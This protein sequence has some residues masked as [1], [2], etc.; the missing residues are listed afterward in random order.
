M[1]VHS[2]MF[3]LF[4]KLELSFLMALLLIASVFY[5]VPRVEALTVSPV[6]AELKA[7]PGQQLRTTFI[8]TNEER[9]TKTFYLSAQNFSAKDESGTPQFSPKKEGLAA[10]AQLPQ[11][12]TLG[13]KEQKEVTYTVSI[14]A[15][16]EPGGYFASIF[17]STLPPE[18]Q[19]NG[20]ISLGSKVGMLVLLRVG[21]AITES[22]DIV[23][24]ETKNKQALFLS[25]PVDFYF[26]FQ[27]SGQSWVKPVGDVVVENIFSQT[28]AIIPA[29][30][31]GSNVLPKS[32]RRY[33][34]S[35]LERGQEGVQSLH[36]ER[37]EP[38]PAGFWNRVKH[39]WRYFALGRYTASVSLTYNN[40]TSTTTKASTSFWVIP[41]HFL[42]VVVPSIIITLLILWFLLKRYNRWVVRRAGKR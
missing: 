15:N 8:L 19:S 28:S 21:G 1:A 41:W 30:P 22:V 20:D 25:L 9:D 32:I 26:R 36:S 6:L 4:R 37:P 3:L 27:N 40:D 34:V 10:W 5:F 23:E 14:P 11:V 33:E 18:E 2:Y 24:F 42:L 17:A 29:N 12:I 35:W 13:P 39:E 38:L 7:E 31:D 16:A